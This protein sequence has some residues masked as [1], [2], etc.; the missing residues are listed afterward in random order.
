MA[1]AAV[2][3]GRGHRRDTEQVHVGLEQL[4]DRLEHSENRPTPRLAGPGVRALGRIADELR[5]SLDF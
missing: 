3:Y 2:A 1:L 4:L 5:K